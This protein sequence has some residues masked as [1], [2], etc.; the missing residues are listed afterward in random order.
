MY[1]DN[2][3]SMNTTVLNF[4]LRDYGH[5]ISEDTLNTYLSC[6]DEQGLLTTKELPMGVVLAILTTRGSDVAIGNANQPSVRRP[7]V[8][9]VNELKE[10]SNR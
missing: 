10:I 6:L 2:N 5:N 9:E 1:S 7:S 3:Y 4:A 8:T